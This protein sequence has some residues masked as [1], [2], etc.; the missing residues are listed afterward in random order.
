MAYILNSF[1]WLQNLLFCASMENE[2]T[3]R[4]YG[5]SEE[6]KEALKRL[7]ILKKTKY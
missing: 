7:Q 6:L 1:V 4:R 5:Y 2:Q 3:A